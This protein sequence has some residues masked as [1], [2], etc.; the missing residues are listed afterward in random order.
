MVS[1][2]TNIIEAGQRF[3]ALALKLISRDLSIPISVHNPHN[4]SDD[5]VSFLFVLFVVLWTDECQ[6]T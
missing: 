2:C 5:V 1:L 3:H 4:G 6:K